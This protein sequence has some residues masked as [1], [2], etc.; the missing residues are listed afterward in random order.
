MRLPARTRSALGC[1][2][3]LALFCTPSVALDSDQ[4][5]P[6]FIEADAVELDDKTSQSLYVGNVDVQ[7]GSLQIL[8]DEVVVHHR[9]DRQPR[10]IIAIG[11][12]AR[13]RQL[14]DGESEEVRGRARR[15]EYDADRDEITFIDDAVLTQGQDS[16]SSDRIVYN[17]T[18]EQVKAGTSAQGRQRV[19]ITITPE[20]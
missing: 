8:A 16:F 14:V 11:E 18:T 5:E 6:L 10:T 15:M 13:Y 19:K 12:P 9:E 17:R 20:E 4:N 7:Q 1:L 2:P 3:L